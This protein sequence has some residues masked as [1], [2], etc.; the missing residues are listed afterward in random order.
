[1]HYGL[2]SEG[3][4]YLTH[5]ELLADELT[6]ENLVEVILTS[7]KSGS[8]QTGNQPTIDSLRGGAQIGHHHI[9]RNTKRLLRISL[10]I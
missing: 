3:G 5:A 1:M 10:L 4:V 7:T 9:G 8:S 6:A 2:G